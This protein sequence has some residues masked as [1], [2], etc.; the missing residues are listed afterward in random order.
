MSNQTL[1]TDSMSY[2][3]CQKKKKKQPGM[4]KLGRTNKEQILNG[5]KLKSYRVLGIIPII[6]VSKDKL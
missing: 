2:Y 3:I 6:A 5:T 1:G 4:Q